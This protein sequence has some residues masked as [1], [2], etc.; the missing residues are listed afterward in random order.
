[1][2]SQANDLK[3]LSCCRCAPP[4]PPPGVSTYFFSGCRPTPRFLLLSCC[5]SETHHV[6]THTYIILLQGA[7]L[8]VDGWMDGRMD[9][10]MVF[11][12]FLKNLLALLDDEIWKEEE[13]KERNNILGMSDYN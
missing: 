7:R 9:G 10:W 4:P 6:L 13:V 3:N 5:A 1:M 12:L 8:N 11:F 2:A